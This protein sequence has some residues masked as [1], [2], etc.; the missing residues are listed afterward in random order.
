VNGVNGFLA[1]NIDEWTAALRTLLA[2]SNQRQRLGAA[3]RA[4]VEK[5]YTVQAA[6]AAV[7]SALR[8]LV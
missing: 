2:D 8:S 5:R 7:N 1:K 4:E 3:G 6:A